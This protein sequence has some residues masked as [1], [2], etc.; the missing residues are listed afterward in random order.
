[1]SLRWWRTWASMALGLSAAAAPA[2]GQAPCPGASA[3]DAEAGWTA[4]AANDVDLARIRFEAA[5][6]RCPNDAYARTGLGYV[7]LRT[8]A[9]SL[10]VALWTQVA[11]LE[12][13]DVDA[14]TGLGLTGMAFSCG[15]RDDGAV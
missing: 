5:L 1:M 7:A 9:D 8:G 4:Y 10:A 2:V 15:R 11:S 3:V 14:L 12:P 13:D 6:G